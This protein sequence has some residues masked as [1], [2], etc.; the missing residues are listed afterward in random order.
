MGWGRREDIRLLCASALFSDEAVSGMT[1]RIV[2][3]RQED[4]ESS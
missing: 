3:I 1:L 2:V 4:R